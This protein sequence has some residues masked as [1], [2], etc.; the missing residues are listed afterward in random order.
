MRELDKRTKEQ[1]HLIGTRLEYKP[2]T[3]A[4]DE[5]VMATYTLDEPTQEYYWRKETRKD[6]GMPTIEPQASLPKGT[7]E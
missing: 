7:E 1:L 2:K 5:L 4:V 6:L 3:W